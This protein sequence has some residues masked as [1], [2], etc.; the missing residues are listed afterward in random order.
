MLREEARQIQYKRKEELRRARK[1]RAA[2]PRARAR[3]PHSGYT[4]QRNNEMLTAAHL[5]YCRDHNGNL[6]DISA[7]FAGM[8]SNVAEL[9]DPARAHRQEPRRGGK[10]R[11]TC[12]LYSR[13][14]YVHTM[15]PL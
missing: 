7:R 5:A 15:V 2:Y 3:I 14:L 1:R 4:R 8:R 11:Y 13:H 12:V 9:T 10:Y 6:R